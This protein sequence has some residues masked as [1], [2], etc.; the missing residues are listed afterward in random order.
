MDA[1]KYDC[2]KNKILMLILV[3]HMHPFI[4]EFA[5]DLGSE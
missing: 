5:L 1:N 4:L 3:P 2:F